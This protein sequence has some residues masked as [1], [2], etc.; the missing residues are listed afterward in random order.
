MKYEFQIKQPPRS[1]E[2]QPENCQNKT[3]NGWFKK[4]KK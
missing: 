3:K 4:K 2:E 1:C